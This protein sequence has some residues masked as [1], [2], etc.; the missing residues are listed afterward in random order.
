M[1]TYYILGAIA[2]IVIIFLVIVAS[3]PGSFRVSRSLAIAAPPDAIF[4]YVNE[5]GKWTL[6]SPFEGIDPSLQ[7]TYEGPAAGV[8]AIYRWNGNNKVGSGSMTV[9]ES[10]PYELVGFKLEFLRPFK[11]TNAVEF[12]FKPDGAKT[13]VT[14][15]MICNCNFVSK[16]IGLFMNMDKMCGEQFEKGLAQLSTVATAK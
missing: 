13:T 10:R 1:T 6:W 5:L 14:W 2:T 11:A 3:R 12:T 8:G 7:R 9:V 15:A 16:A 4:P